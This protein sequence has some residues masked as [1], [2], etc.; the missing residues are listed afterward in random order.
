M[1]ARLLRRPQNICL[2][3]TRGCL[4]PTNRRIPWTCAYC[5]I[6]YPQERN[7]LQLADA[8]RSR[9]SGVPLIP[10]DV[11]PCPEKKHPQGALADG[12]L[13]TATE[14]CLRCHRFSAFASPSAYQK[15]SAEVICDNSL[16]SARVSW[17]ALASQSKA[18]MFDEPFL[19]IRNQYI[20]NADW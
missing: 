2:S 4:L 18:A 1:H 12:M 5:Y 3:R 20:L 11:N 17:L 16:Y 8:R 15:Q 19:C 9:F 10:L 7:A 14:L 13:L 6:G